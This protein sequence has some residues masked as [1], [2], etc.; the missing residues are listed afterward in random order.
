MALSS[1][2]HVPAALSSPKTV[3]CPPARRLEKREISNSVENLT[4]S[5]VTSAQIKWKISVIEVPK[6]VFITVLNFTF[7]HVLSSFPSFS[8]F[9]QY[10]L[11]AYLLFN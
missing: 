10:F 6:S 4:S 11:V 8:S 1:Q 5:P 3:D 2:I 9:M 7:S